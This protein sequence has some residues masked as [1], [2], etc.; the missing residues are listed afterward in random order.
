MDYK[1]GDGVI[2]WTHGLGKGI[3]IEERHL[4]GVSQE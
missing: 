2:H 1:I 3:G 4:A